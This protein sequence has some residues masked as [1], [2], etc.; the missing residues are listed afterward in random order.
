MMRHV[1]EDFA[2]ILKLP[3]LNYPIGLQNMQRLEHLESVK[4]ELEMEKEKREA[5]GRKKARG[6]KLPFDIDLDLGLR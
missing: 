2:G 3:C 4:E 5:G 6:E 1:Q